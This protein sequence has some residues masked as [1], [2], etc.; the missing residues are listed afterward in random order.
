MLSFPFAEKEQRWLLQ[1]PRRWLILNDNNIYGG[2][3]FEPIDAQ[4]TWLGKNVRTAISVLL[5]E[6]RAV[7]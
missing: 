7:A 5:V 3:D 4:K 2:I 1:I 6:A